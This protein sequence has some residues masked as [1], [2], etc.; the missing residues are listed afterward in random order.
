[1]SWEVSKILEGEN[2][3]DLF[4][5][6]VAIYGN[7]AIVGAY[8]YDK[9]GEPVTD[10]RGKVYWYERQRSREWKLIH[11]VEGETANDQFGRSVAIYGNYAIVGATGFDGDGVSDT[12]KVYWYERQRS[13]EWKLIHSVEGENALDTLG[14]S[15]AIYG[16][17]AI[18]SARFFNGSAG[19]D[20]GKVY[21]YERQRSGEWKLI[22]SVE[23]ENGSDKLGDS[24]AIYGNYAI[25]SASNFNGRGVSD[26]GKVYWYERQRSGEWKLIHS[27][28]G[29]NADDYF[30]VSV[31][32]YGN[33]AIVGAYLFDTDS[34]GKVY[35]YERQRSGEWKLIHSV[36]GEN[37]VDYFGRSVAIYGNYAIVGATGG[38]YVKFYQRKNN[39]K[40]EEIAKKVTPLTTGSDDFGDSVSIYENYAMVGGGQGGPG[41]GEG[42]AVIYQR[43][44]NFWD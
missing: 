1:M 36:Q 42:V 7:Y 20:T 9:P 38:N 28:E 24:V 23:G 2:A 15:V 35:W 5:E 16:N 44:N 39:G 34:R 3:N 22:H 37:N 43:D 8:N 41:G 26:T 32:I 19:D 14:G 29:E 40:W 18:V 31:A 10:N 12:G 21:W 25:V 30:G 6:N 33:Y 13:G 17:Y 11:S 27:V 4:G